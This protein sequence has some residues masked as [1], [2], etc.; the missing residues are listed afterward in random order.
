MLYE[1]GC[2]FKAHRDSEK[3]DGMFGTLIIQLPSVFKGSHLIVR[4]GSKTLTVDFDNNRAPHEV[5]YAAHYA[6]CEHEITPL[7][8]GYRLALIYNLVWTA[9]SDPPSLEAHLRNE[10]VLMSLL[11]QIDAERKGV[12]GW[13][14][15]HK[16]SNNS[17]EQ[18]VKALKGTDRFVGLALKN[19]NALLDKQSRFT[20]YIAEIE[21]EVEENG[22]DSDGKL[23][24]S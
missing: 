11:K 18:G 16:Y 24:V 3:E 12:F 13:A 9:T 8:S 21:R 23:E 19:A 4:H 1:E 10:K 6:D 17:L 5:V 7:I 22:Y 14:L 20:F 15:E 2:F